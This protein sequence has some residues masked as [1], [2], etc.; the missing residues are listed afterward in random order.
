MYSLKDAFR[1]HILVKAEGCVLGKGGLS[2]PLGWTGKVMASLL[3]PDLSPEQSCC[4][5]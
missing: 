4:W 2:L 1:W 5:I 3:S